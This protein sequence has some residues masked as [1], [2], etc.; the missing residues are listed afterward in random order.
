MDVQ[1]IGFSYPF[2]VKIKDVKEILD[3][4]TLEE[5]GDLELTKIESLSSLALSRIKTLPLNELREKIKK[6]DIARLLDK[7]FLQ[8]PY[9]EQD[10]ETIRTSS[11]N[12]EYL[13]GLASSKNSIDGKYH[14][15][16]METIKNSQNDINIIWRMYRLAVNEDSLNSPHHLEDMQVLSNYKYDKDIPFALN[17]LFDVLTSKASLESKYHTED[18]NIILESINSINKEDGW[19]DYIVMLLSRKARDKESLQR[20]S[21]I[22]EMK[23]L[24]IKGEDSL[25][26]LTPS[27]EE[28]KKSFIKTLKNKLRNS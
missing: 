25:E 13:I 26:E 15:E 28:P 27:K 24:S 19:S 9:F 21:H 4:F 5:I 17:H 11:R 23:A 20:E 14:L 22:E 2:K 1:Y 16:D 3:Y 18:V 8:N 10:L 12:F 6:E 7:D